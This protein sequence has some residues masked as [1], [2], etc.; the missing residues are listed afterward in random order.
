MGCE[1]VVSGLSG[2]SL[3]L[4]HHYTRDEVVSAIVGH[5]C[6]RETHLFWLDV[7]QEIAR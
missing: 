5:N 6:G 1:V 3:L 7:N 4:D 2:R